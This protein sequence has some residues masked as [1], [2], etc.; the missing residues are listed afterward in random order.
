MLEF[1]CSDGQPPLM[2]KLI[3][4]FCVVLGLAAALTAQ[5]KRLWVLRASGE[6]AEYDPATFAA[7]RTVKVPAEAAATPQGFSVNRLGQMLFAAPISLPL[8]EG[9]LASERKVWFWDG[10]T[11]TTV[12][13]EV[14]RT[15]STTGSNLAITESAPVPYLSADG[16]HLYWFSNQTR[17]LQRDSVDLSAQTT[18]LSWRTDLAGADRQDVASLTLSDCSCPTGGC[19]ETCPYGEMGVPENGVGKFFLLTQFVS[20]KTQPLYKA[21]SLYEENA[22]KWAAT[23]IDP[24]LRRV[25]DAANASALL[26]AIPDTGCCGWEN[27]SDDQTLLHLRGKTLTVFDEQAAY[28]N[29][30]Y[31]VSFYSES[32]KLSPDLDSVALTIVATAQPNT[33]IQLSE[34]GQANPE[35]SQRIRKALLDLPAVEV[36][37][38]ED[39]P[40]RIAFVPHATLVGWISEKEILIVEGHLLIA[41]NVASRTRRKSNVR[42]EDAAH[43]FLR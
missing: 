7:R 32:G 35:E 6:M 34:Q 41:Y 36:K 19:E 1:R 9:D 11:A 24:P 30:D 14:S 15:T 20:G 5:S 8:A 38:V 33:P 10:H 12:T 4:A 18:W 17:R 2:R 42:V 25:L 28:K 3:P 43:V 16:T 40:H 22:G 27:Q 29:P 37:S 13:R 23:P 39:S 31:D 21:T 26:E